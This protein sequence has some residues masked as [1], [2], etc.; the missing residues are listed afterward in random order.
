MTLRSSVAK[1]LLFSC[2]VRLLTRPISGEFLKI[3]L[4]FGELNLRFSFD[5]FIQSPLSVYNPHSPDRLT[6]QRRRFKLPQSKY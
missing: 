5:S 6:R 3:T 1:Q 2:E 4:V